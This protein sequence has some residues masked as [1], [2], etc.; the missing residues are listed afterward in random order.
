ML[1]K[2]IDAWNN[3]LALISLGCLLNFINCH[4]QPAIRAMVSSNVQLGRAAVVIN[5][6]ATTDIALECNHI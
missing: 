6:I 3:L 2:T 1:R 5:N 4:F